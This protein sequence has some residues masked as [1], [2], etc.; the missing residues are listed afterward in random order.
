[1]T[2]GMLDEGIR[3]DAREAVLQSSELGLPVYRR[4]GFEVVCDTA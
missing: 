4:L 1:V 3:R 2:G